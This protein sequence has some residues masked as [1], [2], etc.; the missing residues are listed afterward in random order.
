MAGKGS[1][2]IKI[3]GDASGF[4]KVLGNVESKSKSVISGL[5]TVSSSVAKGVAAAY[6]VISAAWSAVGLVSVKYNASIEQLQTSFTTMTGSAEKAADVV[7]RLRVMGAQTPFELPQLAS[8][9]QLLMQYGFTA[10]DAIDK[11]S[12][13]GDIA[14]GN[15]EAMVSIATGYAQMSSAGKVNLQDIKQM[16]NGGFNPLQEISERTG[17]SMDSLYAR[18]SNGTMSIDEIT[19]SMMYATSEGGKFYKSMEQQSQTLNGQISTIK[20]NLSSLGGA[21]FQPI[22]DL[23]RD[24]LL[25]EANAL[26]AEFQAAFD[27]GGISGLVDS[28]SAQIPRLLSEGV[29]AVTKLFAGIQKQLPKLVKSLMSSIP[30]LV[31]S[32]AS[33]VPMLASSFFDIVASAVTELVAMLPEL[34]PSLIAGI[35]NLIV[36]IATGLGDVVSGIFDGVERAI[37]QGQTK[38]AG[39][40]VDSANVAKHSFDMEIDVSPAVS[41]IESAYTTVRTALQTDLL[42]DAQRQEIL[43]M[44]GADY[45]AIMAKLMSFGLT[46]EEAAPLAEQIAGASATITAEL[47]KLDVGVDAGTIIKWW[48]QAKGSKVAL[49]HFAREAGLDDDDVDEIIG[50][51]DAANGRLRDETPNFYDTIYETLTDGQPDD[52][53]AIEQM[54][55]SVN[56]WASETLGAAEEAYN[57]AVAELDP[58]APDY[59]TRLAE[60]NEE[61]ETT[62]A[63]IKSIRDDSLTII[64]TLAGQTTAQVEAS[65]DMIAELERR[66]DAVE[67]RFVV[68]SD[69]AQSLGET[70]F[71]V[72]RSGAMADETTIDTAIKYKVTQ[73][74]LDEQSA[75]DAYNAAVAEL[76]EQFNSGNLSVD[77]YN[78]GMKD[79]ARTRD[80]AV[81]QAKQEFNQAFGEIMMGIAES[82]GNAAAFD[83]VMANM[84]NRGMFTSVMDGLMTEMLKGNEANPATVQAYRNAVNTM[85]S[86]IL[87]DAYDPEALNYAIQAAQ[88][89]D[90]GPLQEFAASMLDTENFDVSAIS[91]VLRGKVGE[92]WA[93][94]LEGGVLTGTDFDVSATEDQIAA[95]MGAMNMEP[96][97]AGVVAGFG[98]GIEN[99]DLTSAGQRL[100]QNTERSARAGLDEHSPSKKMIPVGEDAAAGVGQ[101]MREYDFSA[102][103]NGMADN[104]GSAAK[105]AMKSPGKRAGILFSAGIASGIRAGRSSVINA[106]VSVAKAAVTALKDELEIHSPSRVT[107]EIGRFTGKGFE[108]GMVESLN[109]AVRAAQSVVGSMNLTP[110]LTAPDLGSAFASAAGSIVDAESARPIYL[111]VNGRALASVTAGDTRRA[112]NSYNRSI[113]LGVGK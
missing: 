23:M 92:T 32:A 13:L 78:Q 54:K 24:K 10:D 70:A 101:G 20:D 77:E 91:D 90:V 48:I 36:S 3:D 85:L 57:A 53:S 81:R 62:K 41:A 7:E 38:I 113:A 39:V 100:A 21:V 84:Q 111:N 73:F 14:Q 2:V 26:I 98:E 68:L 74:K 76:N 83:K 108:L 56:D 33:I 31:R 102:D 16:I 25:P 27:K 80:A 99:A 79:A 97:G 30:A 44:I 71:N 52:E 49:M 69:Q 17:E 40:W 35:G 63:E 45:D 9:T 67:Q 15:A 89:G 96:I 50:V 51:Y 94:A 104:A 105:T 46:E 22:S 1:V 34:I 64:D 55:A 65:F 75:Q 58:D 29:N 107:A 4:E 37:H 88:S 59:Q 5:G 66:A 6:G 28:I 106:A 86:D 93:A 18:V 12:M 42:N 72:V 8:V 60:L 82:E 95:M 19:E 110:R 109:S 103:A 61:Y 43:D 112:Q 11:M 47:N 87:G